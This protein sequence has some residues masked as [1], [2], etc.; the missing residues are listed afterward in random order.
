MRYALSN[1][2][3][4]EP[5]R[6]VPVPSLDCSNVAEIRKAVENASARIAYFQ[7]MMQDAVAT[8]H[9]GDI[10]R[11]NEGA[12]QANRDWETWSKALAK[13]EGAQ[14]GPSGAAPRDWTLVAVAALGVGL[15]V[16][17]FLST[18]R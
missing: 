1:L 6:F 9:R 15:G 16:G 3:Q 4:A 12:Q 10:D 7:K 5:E 14:P 2:G 8:D 11:A 17:W 18:R 13:C